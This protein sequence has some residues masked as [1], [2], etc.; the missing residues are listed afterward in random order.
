MFAYPQRAAFNRILPKNVIYK[1]AQPSNAV[2]KR[3]VSEVS[4]IVWQYKLSNDT[5]NLAPKDGVMEIQVFKITLKAPGLS[6]GILKVIDKAIPYPIFYRLQ[7]EDRINRVTTYKRVSSGNA[8]NC[9]NCII[10]DY[11]ET[12]WMEAKAPEI[13]LPVALN[14]KSLYEQMMV[15]YI[16]LPLRANETLDE[17]VE[18][19]QLIRKKQRE[20]QALE[21]KMAKEK[22]FNRK[23]EIN[24]QIRALHTELK[25]LQ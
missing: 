7:F 9:V 10:E 3:F 5:I 14:L 21:I 20:L 22:Q 12:G 6:K 23:V 16:G 19:I 24:S 2:K 18:R 8:G 17:L 1:N 13:P 4:E 15:F 11:F 25:E